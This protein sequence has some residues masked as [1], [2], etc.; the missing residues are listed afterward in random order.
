MKKLIE[1]L[2]IIG[3]ARQEGDTVIYQDWCEICKNRFED[4]VR[5]SAKGGWIVPRY[6][7]DCIEEKGII[8]HNYA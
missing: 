4:E 5:P 7:N 8:N 1:G 6:C 2:N 3:N